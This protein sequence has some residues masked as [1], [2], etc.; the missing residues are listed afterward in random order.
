MLMFLD[1]T[2]SQNMIDRHTIFEQ[3]ARDEYCS[4]A[5]KR[6]FLR[7]HKRYAIETC[8][9]LDSF[10]PVFECAGLSKKVVLYLTIPITTL[11]VRAGSEFL[12]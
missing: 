1:P 5:L 9:L 12:A 7:T 11:V 6:L 4:M 8:S 2:I 3:P 10:H